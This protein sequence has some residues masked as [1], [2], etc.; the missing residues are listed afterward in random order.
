MTSIQSVERWN[1]SFNS[2]TV[3]DGSNT[4]TVPPAMPG[5]PGSSRLPISIAT[6]TIENGSLVVGTIRLNPDATVTI[7]PGNGGL[8]NE[9]SVVTTLSPA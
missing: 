5:T 2:F 7:A 6:S 3:S 9:L 1:Q 4:W 8:T